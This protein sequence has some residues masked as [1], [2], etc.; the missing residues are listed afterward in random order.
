MGHHDRAK[1]IVAV[2][3]ELAERE[4]IH[5]VTTARLA[6]RM[7]FT[8]AALY[9]YFS[10]KAGILASGLDQLTRHLLS[11]MAL[12]LMQ[13][14]AWK[15]ENPPALL[16]RHIQRFTSRNGLLLVLLIHAA[17]T[18][19]LLLRKVSTE[20]VDTYL[21]NMEKFFTGLLEGAPTPIRPA[22]LAQM[23]LCQLLGGFL[24]CRLAETPWNPTEQPGFTLFLEQLD[25][26]RALAPAAD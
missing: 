10:G 20:F 3:L 19:D 17:E 11:T 8:E 18:Q 15:R 9:R 2:A 6:R 12:E 22:I 14:G 25:A 16:E 13:P 21:G 26:I 4:G 24:R 1:E 23:W 5:G 7:K